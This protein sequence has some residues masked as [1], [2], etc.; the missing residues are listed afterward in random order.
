MN[1]KFNSLPKGLEWIPKFIFISI[2]AL[3]F[4]LKSSENHSIFPSHSSNDCALSTI[5]IKCLPSSSVTRCVCSNTSDFK[6]FFI[7]RTELEIQ[8]RSLNTFQH[9]WRSFYN[10]IY[11]HAK[12]SILISAATQNEFICVSPSV[13]ATS[14]ELQMCRM[15]GKS[16]SNSFSFSFHSRLMLSQLAVRTR[17]LLKNTLECLSRNNIHSSMHRRRWAPQVDSEKKAKVR[18][19]S[20]YPAKGNNF[21]W[22]NIKKQ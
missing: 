10:F 22:R 20:D 15:E 2:S 19:F 13:S 7:K 1:Q 16:V 17:K 12:R 9:E 3:R 21:K 5:C 8:L 4:F 11:I 6:R 14:P 18:H